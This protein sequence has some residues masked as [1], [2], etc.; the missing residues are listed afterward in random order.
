MKLLGPLIK[1]LNATRNVYPA[2]PMNGTGLLLAYDHPKSCARPL[3][4]A[5]PRKNVSF[6][7]KMT[8]NSSEKKDSWSQIKLESQLCNGTA[9][10]KRELFFFFVLVTWIE[11]SCNG[12]AP[13]IAPCDFPFSI[14]SR[15]NLRLVFTS[16]GVG[17]GVVI[18][19]VE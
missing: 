14:Q 15:A 8:T 17:V 4:H 18:R 16:D 9:Q 13:C 2:I 1:T 3:V 7:R 10:N 5:L 6:L 11:M 19:S 12:H